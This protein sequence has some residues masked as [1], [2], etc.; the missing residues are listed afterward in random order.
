MENNFKDDSYLSSFK[1]VEV[2]VEDDNI[3]KAIAIFR[4]IVT[5]ERI[6]SVLKQHYAY[7][8]PSEKRRRKQ[9]ESAQRLR[10]ADRER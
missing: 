8:K 9:R 7:E 1:P 6:M 2:V 5:K 3:V 10:K 4:S